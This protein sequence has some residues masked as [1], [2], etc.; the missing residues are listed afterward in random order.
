MQRISAQ[1]AQQLI[2][3]GAVVLDVRSVDEYTRGHLPGAI[4]LPLDEISRATTVVPDRNRATILYC[5]SGIR[6]ARAA[7]VLTA[8]GWTRIYNLGPITAWPGPLV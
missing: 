1:Q 8:G 7:A 5:G 6:S 2:Q 4:C 3:E